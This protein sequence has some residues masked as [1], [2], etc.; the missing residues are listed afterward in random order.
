MYKICRRARACVCVCV[1]VCVRACV[2]VCVCVCALFSPETLPAGAVKE[3]KSNTQLLQVRAGSP[4]FA[5]DR[6]RSIGA[7]FALRFIPSRSVLRTARFKNNG[8]SACCMHVPVITIIHFR[9][10]PG[11]PRTHRKGH[12]TRAVPVWLCWCPVLALLLCQCPF[13]F[14]SYASAL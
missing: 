2:C 10:L 9:F 11:F 3:L 1:C 6:H 13:L 14:C 4:R 7:R 8:R 12:H 5:G